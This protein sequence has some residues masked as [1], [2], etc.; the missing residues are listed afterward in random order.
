MMD[1]CE[2]GFVDLLLCYF[3]KED[4]DPKID[5]GVL[6]KAPDRLEQKKS[7]CKVLLSCSPVMRSYWQVSEVLVKRMYDVTVVLRGFLFHEGGTSNSFSYLLIYLYLVNTSL[8][9]GAV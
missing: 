1:A 5:Y 9:D 3:P 8:G 2:E 6:Q 7:N 4:E